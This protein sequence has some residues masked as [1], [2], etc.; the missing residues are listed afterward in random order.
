MTDAP[1]RYLRREQAA[2]YVREI[3]GLP[4]STR[5]L[6]KL[7]VV[8]GGPVYRKAGKFPLYQPTDLDVWAQAKIGEPRKSTSSVE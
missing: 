5:W 3:W 6:A 1:S 4:C 8:G 2:Q 7:A